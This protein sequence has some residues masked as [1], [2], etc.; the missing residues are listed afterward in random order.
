M[1]THPNS[2]QHMSAEQQAP[3]P[4]KV[5]RLCPVVIEV[6]C[7]LARLHVHHLVPLACFPEGWQLLQAPPGADLVVTATPKPSGSMKQ[8]ELTAW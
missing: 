5:A 1:L 2:Y 4:A 7:D 3:L 6:S 8:R